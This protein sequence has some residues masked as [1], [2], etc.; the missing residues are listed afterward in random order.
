MS[1][2]VFHFASE[3]V[4]T[5]IVAITKEFITNDSSPEELV[6][7]AKEVLPVHKTDQTT[8]KVRVEGY[9]E[10]SE[11][12]FEAVLD[13]G[14]EKY[15][16]DWNRQKIV[17]EAKLRPFSYY[18]WM[19]GSREPAAN[20]RDRDDYLNDPTTAMIKLEDD[21]KALGALLRKLLQD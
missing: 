12:L 11:V 10:V 19:T 8:W 14:Q 15:G 18:H 16:E 3:E 9:F 17:S 4:I 20:V 6:A 2:N 13:K 1:E 7:K 5:K 21:I